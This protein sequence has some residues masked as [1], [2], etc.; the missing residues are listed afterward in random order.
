MITL[1]LAPTI[2]GD[3]IGSALQVSCVAGALATPWF[4]GPNRKPD[5]SRRRVFFLDYLPARAR[6]WCARRSAALEPIK[7]LPSL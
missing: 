4:G 5:A 6:L 7:S 3:H 1:P 2:R